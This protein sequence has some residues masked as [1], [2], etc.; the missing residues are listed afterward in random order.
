MSSFW[1]KTN[2]YPNIQIELRRI[3]SLKRGNPIGLQPIS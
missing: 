2:V 1:L 3:Q